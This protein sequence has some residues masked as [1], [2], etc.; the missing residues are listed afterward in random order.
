MQPSRIRLRFSDPD[1]ERQFQQEFQERHRYQNRV[2]AV[3]GLAVYALFT[4]LDLAVGGAHWYELVGIRLG[5]TLPLMAFVLSGLFVPRVAARHSSL[6]VAATLLIAGVGLVAMNAR[7][8]EELHNLYF[9]GLLIAV[10]FA[11]AFFRV[12]FRWTTIA[13]FILFVVYLRWRFSF[14]PCRRRT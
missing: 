6:L 3:F 9:T 1:L 14:T 2:A 10:V 13:A 11:L 7:L 12:D 8:P 4:I 5:I